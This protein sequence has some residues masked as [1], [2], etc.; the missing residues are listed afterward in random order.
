M[1]DMG[2]RDEAM[3]LEINMLVLATMSMGAKENIEY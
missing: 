1:S 2:R 3:G